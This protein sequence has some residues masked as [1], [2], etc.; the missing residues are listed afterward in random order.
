M[1][2]K[3][4]RS[5]VQLS[6]L[7]M[8]TLNVGVWLY[9]FRSWPVLSVFC[10]LLLAVI[11]VA[12]SLGHSVGKFLFEELRPDDGETYSYRRRLSNSDSLHEEVDSPL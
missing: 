10:F 9:V 3:L 11:L 1:F 7:F 12:A 4:K 6:P 2:A 8:L 5:F